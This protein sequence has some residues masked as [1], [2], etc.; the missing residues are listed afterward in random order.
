MR[1]TPTKSADLVSQVFSNAVGGSTPQQATTQTELPQTGS[2]QTLPTNAPTLASVDAATSLINQ[3]FASRVLNRVSASREEKVSASS[4][5][6]MSEVAVTPVPTQG[7]KSVESVV[8]SQVRPTLFATKITQ[9]TIN[10]ETVVKSA[11]EQDVAK[12]AAQTDSQ[13]TTDFKVYTQANAVVPETKAHDVPLQSDIATISIKTQNSSSIPE[14]IN[15]INQSKESVSPEVLKIDKVDTTSIENSPV[16]VVID[17]EPDAF[18]ALEVEGQKSNSSNSENPLFSTFVQGKNDSENVVEQAVLQSQSPTVNVTQSTDS[19]PLPVQTEMAEQNPVTEATTDIN[20]NKFVLS[21][22]EQQFADKSAQS[23]EANT[24][25]T[26]PSDKTSTLLEQ[27]AKATLLSGQRLSNPLPVQAESNVEG[28]VI[29][30]TIIESKSDK[31]VEPISTPIDD[32]LPVQ[33]KT[34]DVIPTVKSKTVDQ[35]IDK[36]S[37]SVSEVQPNF[38][39]ISNTETITQTS[40]PQIQ[41]LWRCLAQRISRKSKKV[42]HKLFS[43]RK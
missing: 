33:S 2:V 18:V 13:P 19:I 38:K 41:S 40:L 11:V 6:S 23:I 26:I 22:S 30:A 14:T 28:P 10:T 42:P 24:T 8:E 21:S 16:P 29:K 31:I 5:L 25:T 12:G 9:P 32:L 35:S 34:S 36:T 3:E 4:K 37:P 7:T 17:Q 15:E 43:N 20:T 27:Q 1:S 39:V